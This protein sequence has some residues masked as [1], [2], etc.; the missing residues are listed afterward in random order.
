MDHEK[1]KTAFLTIDLGHPSPGALESLLDTLERLGVRA[2]FFIPASLA[3][4]EPGLVEEVADRGH[5][6]GSLGYTCSRLDKMSPEEA[7]SEVTRGIRLL[8]EL[9]PVKSFRAP[10]MRLPRRLLPLLS[11]EGILVDSSL[12]LHLG[13]ANTAPRVEGGVIR[14]PVTHGDYLLRMP[15]GMQKVFHTAPP[16]V[17]VF[18]VSA[19]RPLGGL[20]QDPLVRAVLYYLEHGY[21]FAT[22]SEAVDFYKIIAGARV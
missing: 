6:V 5:E 14:L 8:R 3:K 13:V 9:Y 7:A 21:R 16:R 19:S 20:G 22:M 18:R 1:G 4:R 11:R 10:Y 15:W 12:R 17:A 2:T